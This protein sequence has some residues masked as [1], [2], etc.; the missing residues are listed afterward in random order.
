MKLVPFVLTHKKQGSFVLTRCTLFL[1]H[2]G[3][4]IWQTD[5]AGSISVEK[6]YEDY[7][8]P[9]GFVVDHINLDSTKQIAFAQIDPVKTSFAEF[10]T[11]E[12][13]LTKSE[14][15]ECWRHFYFVRDAEQTDWWSP[16]GIVEADFQSGESLSDLF[17][18]ILSLEGSDT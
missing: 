16:R 13:A 8:D 1:A 6:L 5:E 17:Q 7:L 2:A 3:K 11:W 9:N 18:E 10:Y 4:S 12:E 14:K 15:P